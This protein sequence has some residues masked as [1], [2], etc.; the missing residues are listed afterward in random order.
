MYMIV[1]AY[2]IIIMNPCLILIIGQ[3]PIE[4]LNARGAPQVE[5]KLR[6]AASYAVAKLSTQGKAPSEPGAAIRRRAGWPCIDA[7][8]R[9]S[10][11]IKTQYRS[12]WANR[13][14][15]HTSSFTSMLLC[16]CSGRPA[17]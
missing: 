14:R 9:A 6:L 7:G 17:M 15:S 12:V 4:D 5:L 11:T 2:N 10:N 8:T 13:A 16:I 1:V 3:C